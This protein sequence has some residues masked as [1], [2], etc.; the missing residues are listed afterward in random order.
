M[1]LLLGKELTDTFSP[2]MRTRLRGRQEQGQGPGAEGNLMT[3]IELVLIIAATIV[4][5]HVDELVIVLVA[6][7]VVHVPL[8]A[9]ASLLVLLLHALVL[10]AP[11]LEPDFHLRLREVQRLG[12]C[13]PLRAHHILIAL[14]CVL[15]LQQ[16]RRREGGAN[17]LWLAEWLQQEVYKE[18]ERKGKK[19]G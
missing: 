8:R 17:A 4:H 15:Q 1:A 14:E 10:G 9:G 13:L 7:A 12:E 16:L 18:R 11:V 19:S 2:E 6:A 5:F 3:R